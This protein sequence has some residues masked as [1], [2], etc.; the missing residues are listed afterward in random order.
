MIGGWL[1]PARELALSA[2]VPAV[3]AILILSAEQHGRLAWSIQAC[4]GVVA[5]FVPA[6]AV[7]FGLFAALLASDAWQKDTLAR[8]ILNDEVDERLPD[9]RVD[10]RHAVRRDSVRRARGVDRRRAEGPLEH[11]A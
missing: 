9:H 5:A 11:R 4:K 8:R 2:I 10:L 3:L 7:V 6:I 1:S